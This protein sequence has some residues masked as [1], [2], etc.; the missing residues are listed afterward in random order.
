MIE[1]NDLAPK[2]EVVR[3]EMERF[4]QRVCQ[5]SFSRD[6]ARVDRM[7]FLINNYDLVNRVYEDRG[8]DTDDTGR[9][10]ELLKTQMHNF[11]DESIGQYF[12]SLMNCIKKYEPRVKPLEQ[13]MTDDTI[14]HLRRDNLRS[15]DERFLHLLH[16]LLPIFTQ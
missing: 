5:N 9:F 3:A 8:V 4:L 10:N 1:V 14:E 2:L 15:I 11:V 7:V 12:S 6:R 13:G 16:L